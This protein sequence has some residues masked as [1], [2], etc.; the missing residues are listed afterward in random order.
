M[1]CYIVIIHHAAGIL[2]ILQDFD[3]LAS[4]INRLFCLIQ[5]VSKHLYL[6]LQDTWS[7]KVFVFSFSAV[8][9]SN[10]TSRD[11]AT[12][13]RSFGKRR[14]VYLLLLLD[15]SQ[16]FWCRSFASYPLHIS[17]ETWYNEESALTY[18]LAHRK[19]AWHVW[20]PWSF[21]SFNSA[22]WCTESIAFLWSN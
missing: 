7:P 18:F 2:E 9:A 14:S 4:S 17:A 13:T 20:I 10:R 15:A 19:E 1:A 22:P 5:W 3:D 21:M 16:W 6:S 8:I 11:S 12:I